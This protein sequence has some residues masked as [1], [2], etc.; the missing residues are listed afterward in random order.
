LF[1]LEFPPTAAPPEPIVIGIVPPIATDEMSNQVSTSCPAPPPPDPLCDQETP[2]PPEPPPPV[3]INL[4]TG[5]EFAGRVQ[6]PDE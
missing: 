1:P 3:K 5:P 6:F 2:H 4:I